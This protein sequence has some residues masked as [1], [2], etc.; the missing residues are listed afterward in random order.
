VSD[1]LELGGHELLDAARHEAARHVDLHHPW[2]GGGDEPAERVSAYL[3]VLWQVAKE[4]RIRRGEAQEPAA[5]DQEADG[6]S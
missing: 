2:D 5:G 3:A 6:A 4:V 1:L